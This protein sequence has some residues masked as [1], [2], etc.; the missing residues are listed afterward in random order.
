MKLIIQIPCYNEAQTLPIT[1]SALPRTVAGFDS[2]EIVVIDDGSH[3]GTAAVA[4]R[5]GVDHVLTLEQN[6]GLAT[7]FLTGIRYSLMLG[8][9]V[10]VNTDA[11]NQYRG[12][13]IALLTAP[14][15][16]GSADFV[17]GLRPVRE[18]RVPG[19]KKLLHWMGSRVVMAAS[20]TA[21]VD[22]PSGFRA[23]SSHAASR[24]HVFNSYTYTLETIIQ[25]GNS[26]LRTA[27]VPI[28]I[29]GDLR[30]SRLISNPFVYIFKSAV[31]IVRTF[32]IYR[33]FSVL[34]ASGFLLGLV[35]CVLLAF[36]EMGDL[37]T[38]R[39]T[40]GIA[41]LTAGFVAAVAAFVVDHLTACRKMLEELVAAKRTPREGSTKS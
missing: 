12:D 35:G 27:T 8:A 3:D 13:D 16:A 30:P 14:I 31:I 41:C 32:M 23:F 2:L 17:V 20:G 36:P 24:L 28:R 39:I 15:V 5:H 25:A 37:C 34:I 21:I 40:I 9:D 7:A 4:K 26:G 11:D 38:M 18:M 19:W 1:L 29:N 22:A 6:C 10:I 33:G